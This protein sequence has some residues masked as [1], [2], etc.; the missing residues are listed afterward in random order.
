MTIWRFITLLFP[1]FMKKALEALYLS[2]DSSDTGTVQEKWPFLGHAA[3]NLLVVSL[4]VCRTLF[5]GR[6][7][8]LLIALP[9]KLSD[10]C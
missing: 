9:L 2:S 4:G 3:C 6:S 1:P 10:T 5:V 7:W 8:K